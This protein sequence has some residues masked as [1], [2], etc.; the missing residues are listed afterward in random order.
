[1]LLVRKSASVVDDF[2]RVLVITHLAFGRL[3]DTAFLKLLSLFFVA[4]GADKRSDFHF[5]NHIRA[6]NY[7]TPERDQFFNIRGFHLT[8][9]VHLSKVVRT[10]LDDCVGLSVVVLHVHIAIV[11]VFAAHA[12]HTV[13]VAFFE[14]LG[15]YQIEDRDD[16]AWVVFQLAV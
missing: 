6:T 1:M 7:D 5:R 2:E 15:D 4:F 14:T 3:N 12:N 9:A 8:D 10:Y 16:I 11:L 13:Q